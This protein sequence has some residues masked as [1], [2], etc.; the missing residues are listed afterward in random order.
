MRTLVIAFSVAM[1]VAFSNPG[2][3]QQIHVLN[4]HL[5]TK[6]DPWLFRQ[7]C[8]SENFARLAVPEA[9]VDEWG[10][11]KVH[12]KYPYLKKLKKKHAYNKLNPKYVF[13]RKKEY[14]KRKLHY[15]EKK[16]YTEF[17]ACKK[18]YKCLLIVK[19]KLAKLH[20]H[21]SYNGTPSALASGGSI[22]ESTTSALSGVTR[23]LTGTAGRTLSSATNTGGSLADSSVRTT[24]QTVDGAA[25]IAGQTVG[26]AKNTLGK[27]AEGTVTGATNTVGGLLK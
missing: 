7:H 2:Q 22:G 1:L 11:P 5:M 23:S 4:C 18:N 21:P 19:R 12:K 24:S 9:V 10:K 6:S 16:L 3:A 15:L 17:R 27:T 20:R 14:L 25:N 13:L 8:K 26:A